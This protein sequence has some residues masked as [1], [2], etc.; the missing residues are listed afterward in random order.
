VVFVQENAY[1]GGM[2]VD[3]SGSSFVDYLLAFESSH[4]SVMVEIKTPKTK[5][6]GRKYRQN[7]PVS[8]ELAGSITQVLDYRE[9]LIS[10]FDNI[11]R[12]TEHNIERIN[13]RCALIIG[14]GE[15]ELNSQEKRRSFEL[16]RSSYRDIEII[17]YDELFKKVELLAQLFH[18]KRTARP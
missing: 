18:L 10:D 8:S 6:L 16:F 12:E 11:T 9:K 2:K 1:V 17:T 4:N 14:N 7:Y 5:L 13:P 3:G 15:E